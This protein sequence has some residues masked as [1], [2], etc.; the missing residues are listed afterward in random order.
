MTKQVLKDSHFNII[1]YI[2]TKA[3]GKQVITDSHFAIKGYFDPKSNKTTDSHFR[4]V[5]TGNLLTSLL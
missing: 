5:G 2:E 4:S 1:G 3:D